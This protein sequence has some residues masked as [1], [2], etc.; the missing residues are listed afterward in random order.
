MNEYLDLGYMEQVTEDQ[1]SSDGYYLPH[2]GVIK[3]S[4]ETTKLRVVFDGSAG[5]SSGLS[6][7]D[8]LHTGPKVQEDLLYILLRFRLYRYVIT[9]D[10]EKMYRQ[11]LVRE[12][13]R[14]YQ[15]ILWRDSSDRITTFQL[16]TVTFGLLAAPLLAIR[17]LV[18]LAHDERHRFPTASNILLRDFYVDDLLTG[19][20]TI[21]EARRIR[22]ELTSLLDTAKLNI[23]QW[24]SNSDSPLRDLPEQAINKKLHIGESSTLKTLGVVWNSSQDTIS[25]EVKPQLAKTNITKRFISS[26]IAKIYDPLGLLGPVI[27]LAKVLLQKL[28]TIR[29]DWD[30]SL[31]MDIY[32]EWVTFYKQLPLLNN[33]VF[34]RYIII[35]SPISIELH[36][37]CDASEKTYGACIYVRSTNATG[38]VQVDLLIAKS[39]V[40]PLKTQSIPRLE[41]CAA[42]LLSTLMTTVRKALHLQVQHTTFWSD[43]TIVLHWLRTSPHLL[44]TFIANRISKI[45]STTDITH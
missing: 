16:K 24:V 27:I 37:F 39:K 5:T 3:V 2:H 13:D 20:T 10:I 33:T 38:Q 12:E 42:L 29:V 18:Q 15:R 6:L 40:A 41:L 31:S 28:W 34:N 26:E 30:E 9:G 17:S 35:A 45:Q 19:A 23:R 22:K 1:D 11:F 7:N 8:T 44:K 21:E 32:T 36:G 43:S 14:K 25:Y 4:S